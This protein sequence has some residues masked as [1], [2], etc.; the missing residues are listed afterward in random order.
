MVRHPPHRSG[1]GR[2]SS[3][4]PI[5]D[6]RARTARARQ[7]A[8]ALFAPKPPPVTE[9]LVAGRDPPADQSARQR[10][11]LGTSSPVPVR[12]EVAEAPVSPVIPTAHFAR[13][14]TW[15]KYG[16]AVAQVAQVYGVPVG[17]VERVLGKT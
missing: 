3:D 4:R 14:R 7:D 6:D 13:I 17:E 8:E 2:A 5:P 10:R 12:P 9:K 1:Y 16:M 11:V 15:V